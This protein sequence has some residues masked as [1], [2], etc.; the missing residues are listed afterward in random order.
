MRCRTVPS[1]LKAP[2]LVNRYYDPGTGQ[3]LTV[4]PMVDETGQPYSYAGGD[5]VNGSD[6]SG[7]VTCP[8]WVPGC[9]TVTDAQSAVSGAYSSVTT[10]SA[11]T[12][13]NQN[14]NPAYLALTG[15]YNEWE[16]TENGCGLGTELGYGAQGVLGVA[17]TLSLAV[18]G[19]EVAGFIENP[20]QFFQIGNRGFH[21][22]FDEDPH[23]DIGSH[24]QIDS[25]FKG[26]SGSGRSWRL[27]WPPW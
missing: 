13:F 21:L 24:L 16:A 20:D 15:Y 27:P 23:G 8:S 12:W 25:W 22:H 5:P 11:Y 7:D 2:S 19:G 14:L 6:P 1:A 4:D 9:G 10:S 17:G 3:F 26:V 18:G